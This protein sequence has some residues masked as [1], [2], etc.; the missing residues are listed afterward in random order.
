MVSPGI[1]LWAVAVVNVTTLEVRAFLVTVDV[2]ST[3]VGSIRRNQQRIDFDVPDV[4]Q[5]K[6]LRCQ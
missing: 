3:G 5:E 6:G 4:S 1:K 2:V